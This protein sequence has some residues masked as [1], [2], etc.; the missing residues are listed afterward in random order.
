MNVKDKIIL[1][2]GA[3]GQQGGAV[4]RHLLANGW[5][6]RA[7]SRDP[8]AD[9]ARWLRELGLEIKRGDLTSPGVVAQAMEGVYGVFAMGTPFEHGIEHEIEQGTTL[10]EAAKAAG[11]KHYV[12][13]SVGGADRQSG[14]PHFVSKW[15]V[16]EHL[17]SLDL[18]LTVVRPVF[19]M[20]NLLGRTTQRGEQGR[21]IAMPLAPETR[22]QM[23]AVD[24]IGGLTAAV[25]AQPQRFIG[26]A[27]EIAGDDLTMPD[28]AARLAA[29][30][31]E[32]VEYE[33]IPYA[34]VRQHSNDMA[35]MYEWF[36]HN[37]YTAGI[38]DL[39]NLY[40]HLRTFADWAGETATRALKE[41]A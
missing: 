5:Q 32:R 33:R 15:Q 18:P 30:L 38:D 8:G 4:T 19:F 39:R 37:G 27:L 36:D 35:L 29:A 22:L 20:E 12:Y 17:R 3:T 24:D 2:T 31:D 41:A 11:V 10:A 7:V 16:E 1:V 23:I 40:P 26:T 9:K 14:V 34:A 6:V 28:A 21:T 25:F 13:S